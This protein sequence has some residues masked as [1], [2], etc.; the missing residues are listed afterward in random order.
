MKSK[1]KKQALF[2]CLLKEN[3][4]VHE[5]NTDLKAGPKIVKTKEGS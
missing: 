3:E 5:G 1:C 2:V 4:G